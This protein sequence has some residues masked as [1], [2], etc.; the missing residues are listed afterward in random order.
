[1][2]CEAQ[3][4]SYGQEEENMFEITML[5]LVL[6][7]PSVFACLLVEGVLR[8]RRRNSQVR[9]RPHATMP[10]GRLFDT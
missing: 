3:A 4:S 10:E 6:L 9:S 1:V 5:F 8:S 7:V 2:D